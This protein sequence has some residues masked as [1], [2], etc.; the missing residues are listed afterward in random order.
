MIVSDMNDFTGNINL[1]ACARVITAGFAAEL[2]FRT[3]GSPL[4]QANFQL[5]AVAYD[6]T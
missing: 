1:L 2:T 6:G 5:A 4:K 3:P